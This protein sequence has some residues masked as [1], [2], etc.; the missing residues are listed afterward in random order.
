MSFLLCLCEGNYFYGVFTLPDTDTDTDKMGLQPICTCVGVC[1]C[2]GQYEHLHTI[3]YNP[4]FI[5]VCVGVGQCKHSISGEWILWYSETLQKPG[6]A[7]SLQE[8]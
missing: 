3:L 4:F 1:V 7:M 6:L 5:G 8:L 2:V